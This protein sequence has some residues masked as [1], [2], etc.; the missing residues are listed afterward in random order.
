QVWGNYLN[1]GSNE[2]EPWISDAL[3]TNIYGTQEARIDDYPG[4]PTPQP[5]TL[6]IIADGNFTEWGRCRIKGALLTQ[7][8][9]THRWRNYTDV[10]WSGL[11]IFHNTDGTDTH[12]DPSIASRLDMTGGTHYADKVNLGLSLY[13]VETDP[14]DGMGIINIW[15]TGTF[16]VEPNSFDDPETPG[17]DPPYGTYHLWIADGSFIDIRDDGQLRVPADADMITKTDGFITAGKIISGDAIRPLA[18]YTIGAEY[19]VSL[20]IPGDFNLDGSVDVSDLGILAANYGTMGGMVWG[21]GDAT[22]DTN[23]DVSDLGILAA[24]YGTSPS[25]VSAVPEPTGLCL[26]LGAILCLGLF[27]RRSSIVK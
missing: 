26:M 17:V 6:P 3:P 2:S 11:A 8:G 18:T 15:G 1:W 21:N 22:A 24:N 27:R 9:G 7:T 23:V 12:T 4:Q 5:T 14:I 10:T 16:V 20:A 19:V 25:A 13:D